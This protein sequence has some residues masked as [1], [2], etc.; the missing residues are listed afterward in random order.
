MSDVR[1]IL[2]QRSSGYD[3]FRSRVASAGLKFS[4]LLDSQIMVRLLH[5]PVSSFLNQA[6][7]YISS[8]EPGIRDDWRVSR[9]KFNLPRSRVSLSDDMARV[10]DFF[11]QDWWWWWQ[12]I[13][14]Q[15]SLRK[16]DI[17]LFM[18]STRAK[19]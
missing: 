3:F 16:R 13:E 6:M 2:K 10:Y 7:V 15:A 1:K 17:T 12:F 4:Y 8:T 5:T 18:L 19:F 14:H 9:Q 11:C